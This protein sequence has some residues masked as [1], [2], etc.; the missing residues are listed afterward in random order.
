M[1]L[2]QNKWT[3]AGG[4]KPGAPGALRDSAQLV[5]VFG[6]TAIMKDP[7]HYEAIRTAYP[8]AHIMGGTTSGEIC[9]TSVADDSLVVT[10]VH[11]EHTALKGARVKLDDME[12]SFEAGEQLAKMLDHHELAHVFVISDGLKVNGSELVK[13]LA[14]NLP[15]SVAIT[16]GLAG[17]GP[18][19]ERTLVCFDAPPESGIVAALGLYGNRLKVGYGS[20]GGWDPFGVEWVITKSKANVLRELDGQS[21]LKL[22]K[23]YLGEHA[24]ELP[25]SGLLFPLSL[26]LEGSDEPVVRTILAVSDVEQSMPF[27]GDVPQGARARFMKANFDRLVDGASGAARKTTYQSIGS[28]TP[29]LA[30]LISC[31]GRKLVL[32]QRIEEEVEG[33]RDVLGEGA[34]LAGFYS[35]GEISP[36]TPNAKCELHNQTMTIT[37]F[38]EV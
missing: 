5:L 14:A 23:D 2:E 6:A 16:G 29:D 12:R 17:D 19:F 1:K 9:G 27:A 30:V 31:V 18:R 22:Y 28:A 15:P 26:R 34:M 35:Y 7:Q 20:M 37:T 38:S 3:A 4:W 36:F 25:A 10:A 21:A 24:K 13:G 8:G 33:V 11:F 32:K